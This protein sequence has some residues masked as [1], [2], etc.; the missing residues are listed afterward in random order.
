MTCR[1]L[2]LL[3]AGSVLAACEPGKTVP[4]PVCDLQAHQALVGSNIGEVTLPSE[5]PQR[6]ISPG[7]MVTQD[8]NP[9]RLN[10]FVDPKGWIGKITCG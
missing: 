4:K 5:L 1:M 10:I 2:A 3:A 6:V 9:A 7:D 8:Y